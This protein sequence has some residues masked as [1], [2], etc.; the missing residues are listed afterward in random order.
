MHMKKRTFIGHL[1]IIKDFLKIFGIFSIFLFI[2]IYIFFKS[3][4]IYFFIKMLNNMNINHI[5][6]L[7][8]YDGFLF[9]IKLTF[10]LWIFLLLIIFIT[11]FL[12]FLEEKIL[13]FYFLVSLPIILYINFNYLIPISWKN[14]YNIL[15]IAGSYFITLKEITNFIFTIN[16][17]GFVIFYIPFFFIILYIYKIISEKIFH[18]VK[19]YWCLISVI[20]SGIIAPADV[21]SHIIMSLFMILMFYI[22]LYITL[23]VKKLVK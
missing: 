1:Q 21:F 11:G 10:Y 3:Q 9:P 16:L 8:I 23:F 13:N 4:I 2:I 12:F 19:K 17:C 22:L 18:Q 20:I 15:P 14:F 6:Y 5:Y 7:N